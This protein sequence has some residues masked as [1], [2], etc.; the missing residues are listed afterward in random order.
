MQK[1]VTPDRES[2]RH[3][4]PILD[5][6]GSLKRHALSRLDEGRT[7]KPDDAGSKQTGED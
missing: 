4:E 3:V 5:A 1:I 7:G 2:Y 6:S